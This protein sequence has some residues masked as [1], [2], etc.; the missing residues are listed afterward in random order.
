MEMMKQAQAMA[1]KPK[2]PALTV[3]K[4]DEFTKRLESWVQAKLKEYD[5]DETFRESRCKKLYKSG[6]LFFLFPPSAP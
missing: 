1:A 5:T 4:K 6:F 2:K 3:A